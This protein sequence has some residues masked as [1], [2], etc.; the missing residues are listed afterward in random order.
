MS[1]DIT[2]KIDIA[3]KKKEAGDTAFKAGDIKEGLGVLL[4]TNLP[5]S[6]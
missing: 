4:A 5:V 2:A 6:Q 3:K 1:L